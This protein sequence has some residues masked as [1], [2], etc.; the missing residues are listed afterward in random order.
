MFHLAQKLGYQLDAN[1][2]QMCSE[3]TKMLHAGNI[4]DSMGPNDNNPPMTEFPTAFDPCPNTAVSKPPTPP[5]PPFEPPPQPQEPRLD[6][7]EQK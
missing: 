7:V 6:D 5:E 2:A 3:L 1:I 4:V